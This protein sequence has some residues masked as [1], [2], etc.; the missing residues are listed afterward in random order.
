MNI[1]PAIDLLNMKSVRLAR[2]DSAAD[3]GGGD[4]REAARRFA[5][6]G[7]HRLHLTDLNGVLEGV[8]RHLALA[9]EIMDDTGLPVQIAGGFRRLEKIDEAVRLGIDR[10]I[11]GQGAIELPAL[12]EDACL[13]HGERIALAVEIDG[14]EV[15]TR[16][17]ASVS[18]HLWADVLVHADAAGLGR[19]LLTHLDRPNESARSFA[20]IADVR[21]VWRK[22][23]IV[24]GG[25]ASLDEVRALAAL[26]S[27]GPEAVVVGRALHEKRFGLEEAMRTG[28]ERAE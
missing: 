28:G 16:E 12:L 20:W 17:W 3:S 23:L 6:A 24:A 22:P 8:P 21:K 27:S 9:R 15:S 19:V 4:P 25:I 18:T 10:V 2:A 1:I 5:A 26:G 11:L 7:A 13:S 14:D